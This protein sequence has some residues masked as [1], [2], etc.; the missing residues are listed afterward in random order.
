MRPEEWKFK[1]GMRAESLYEIT[2]CSTVI[3]ALTCRVGP[4]TDPAFAPLTV[5]RATGAATSGVNKYYLLS[6]SE[7]SLCDQFI[8]DNLS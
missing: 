4:G 6:G 3:T 7:N 5:P 1:L 2:S 8:V